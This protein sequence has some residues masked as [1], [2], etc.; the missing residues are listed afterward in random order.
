MLQYVHL[1]IFFLS[2]SGVRC[3][4]NENI[5]INHAASVK[6]FT[7]AALHGNRNIDIKMLILIFG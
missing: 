1:C 5:K 6:N 7:E 4:Y 3:I 2:V